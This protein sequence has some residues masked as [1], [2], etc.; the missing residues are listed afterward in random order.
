MHACQVYEVGPIG[1]L[2][3]AGLAMWIL[4]HGCRV[5]A[6]VGTAK[7]AGAYGGSLQVACARPK[8]RKIFRLTGLD[9]RIPLA[10][11][12]ARPGRQWRQGPRHEHPG[13]G[14]AGPPDQRVAQTRLGCWSP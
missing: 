4:R 8:I 5:L 3:L 13:A 2:V 6:L 14:T 9:A 12:V 11:T 7:R 1:G 10:R